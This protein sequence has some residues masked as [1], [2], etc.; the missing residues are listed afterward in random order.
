MAF[1]QFRMGVPAFLTN[2]T[3]LAWV[4]FWNH[5]LAAALVS[6][7]AAIVTASWLLHTRVKWGRTKASSQPAATTQRRAHGGGAATRAGNGA[8]GG[9][10]RGALRLQAG[11]PTPTSMAEHGHHLHASDGSIPVSADGVSVG[12]LGS[13]DTD[14]GHRHAV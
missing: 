2:L 14:D 9:G 8:G 7:V 10:G 4:K 3:M 13:R 1:K 11:S 5:V 6:V 12:S